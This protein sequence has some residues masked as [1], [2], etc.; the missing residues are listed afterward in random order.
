MDYKKEFI[1][2]A[3]SA[4]RDGV[5]E[6]VNWLA[7]TDFFKAPAST[8]YH[9]NYEGGLCE[10]SVIVY[11]KLKKYFGDKI[12]DDTAIIIALFHDV[13]KTRY[14]DVDYRNRKN[15]KGVWEKVPVYITNDL[16]PYG[17]GEKSVYLVSKFIDLTDDEAMAIRWH[18][19]A[20]E[21]EKV[22]GTLSKAY[23]YTPL[24]LYLHTADMLATY[25]KE[26]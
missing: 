21:G 22:W 4:K 13:C 11:Q 16:F 1:R 26:G 15:E 6:L 14:Y 17:H 25:D 23:A 20:Y 19:G 7:K 8:Q 12:D 18:M 24:A 5:R 2:I 9:E 3:G 10:H